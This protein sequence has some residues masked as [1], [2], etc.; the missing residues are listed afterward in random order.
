[1]MFLRLYTYTSLGDKCDCV[2]CSRKKILFVFVSVLNV[3][4]LHEYPIEGLFP[5]KFSTEVTCPLSVGGET[6]MA[7]V[8]TA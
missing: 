1:M 4:A 7:T 6:V 3:N 8:A 2:D 5:V